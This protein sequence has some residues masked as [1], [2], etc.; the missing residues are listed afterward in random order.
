[1]SKAKLI[2]VV[3]GVA[4]IAS[5]YFVFILDPWT[6]L[7]ESTETWTEDDPYGSKYY[8]ISKDQELTLEFLLLNGE[9]NITILGRH[10]NDY[11]TKLNES[12]ETETFTRI[13]RRDFTTDYSVWVT[14]EGSWV[15]VHAVIRE[16]NSSMHSLAGT[17]LLVLGLVLV[18]LPLL[19]IRKFERA[20]GARANLRV[21]G[22]VLVVIGLVMVFLFLGGVFIPLIGTAII[23]VGIEL[24]LVAGKM[25]ER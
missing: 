3:V 21:M 1:M 8:W 10:D 24:I 18:S 6:T 17:S 15:R 20:P 12:H 11:T 25:R 23:F 2:L 19:S 13:N 4:L 5:S 7:S 22:V 14:G 9:M 16:D